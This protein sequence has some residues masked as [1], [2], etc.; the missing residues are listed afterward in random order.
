MGGPVASIG[1]HMGALIGEYTSGIGYTMQTTA[2]IS[3]YWQQ[4]TMLKAI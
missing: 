3:G 1:A 2:L 4:R